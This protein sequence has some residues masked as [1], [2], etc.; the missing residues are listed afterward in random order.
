MY[1]MPAD[2]RAADCDLAGLIDIHVHS[3][4]D[5]RPRLL[6]DLQVVQ[7][8]RDAGMCAIM[9]K[10][11]VTLTADRAAM[12]EKAVPGLRVL[13]GLALNNP[14]GGLNPAAVDA[15]IRMG[16]RQIW[17]P[18]MSAASDIAFQRRLGIASPP[19]A[20]PGIS[21]LRKDGS[22]DPLV[23][24]ILSLVAQAGVVVSTGHLSPR[25]AVALVRAA[26]E[27]GVQ[28]IIVT[29]PEAGLSAM[30][31]SMQE[32]LALP[33]VW[34]ELCYASVLEEGGPPLAEVAA[35]IRAVGPERVIL[36]SDLGVAVDGFP[37][38]VE[39]LRAYLS[40]LMKLGI[41][42]NDIRI[43]GRDNPACLFGL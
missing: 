21:I 19:S 43:M 35:R 37:P 24:E 20:G 22:L 15:A 23:H 12:A 32:E 34:F 40:G 18:T 41:S 1:S 27:H 30:P 17:M 2:E 7:A 4:P 29:H 36:S 38:P 13:G 33:G 9:L 31:L 42:W 39:G 14:V 16:A 28:R 8:A 3:A 6:D 5:V 10:S 11:H 25:E 26:R